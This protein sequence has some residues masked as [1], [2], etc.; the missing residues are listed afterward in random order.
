MLGLGCNDQG[1]QIEYVIPNDFRG[2]DKLRGETIDGESGHDSR[3]VV[4]RFPA[5]GMLRIRRPLPTLE[6]HNPVAYYE[7][8]RSIPVTSPI[9][10]VS[11]DVVALRS[12]GR[13]DNVEDWYVVGTDEDHRAALKVFYGPWVESF[14]PSTRVPQDRTDTN[15]SAGKPQ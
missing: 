5:S 10:S 1:I 6:W 7:D 8:G 11:E 14:M 9:L 3:R 2:I 12:V 15:D 13:K 4:L